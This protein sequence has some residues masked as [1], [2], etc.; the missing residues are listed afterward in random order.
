MTD[1]LLPPPALPPGLPGV[2]RRPAESAPVRYRDGTWAATF[3]RFRVANSRTGRFL[4]PPWSLALYGAA[5]FA[6]P[7]VVAGR[8]GW[9]FLE[10]RLRPPAGSPRPWIDPLARWARVLDERL[11]SLGIDLVLMPVPSK[12]W[13]HPEFVP[14]GWD[15]RQRLHGDLMAALREEGLRVLDLIDAW[16][17]TGDPAAG[18]CKTDSHWNWV[19]ARAAA[20]AIAGAAGVRVPDGERS[21]RLREVAVFPD[22][23]DLCRMFGVDLLL[24]RS[25]LLRRLLGLAAKPVGT[26]AAHTVVRADG[27]P[28]PG[29]PWSGHA[30][31]LVSG[32]S[33]SAWPEFDRYL[34]HASGGRIRLV[35]TRGGGISESLLAAVE[36]ALADPGSERPRTLVWEFPAVLLWIES[37][38]LLALGDVFGLLPAA[39][40]PLPGAA[41]RWQG[42]LAPG[43]FDAGPARSS[44]RLVSPRISTSDPGDLGVRL[45]GG[46]EGA[47]ALVAVRAGGETVFA[48]WRP[49]QRELVLPLPPAPGDAEIEVAVSAP[50]GA[51]RIR[52][53]SLELVTAPAI[54][55]P[56]REPEAPPPTGGP[57]LFRLPLPPGAEGARVGIRG[58]AAPG[59]SVTA[60]IEGRGES[61]PLG[62]PLTAPPGE[63]AA[64]W[65]LPPATPAG[66]VLVLSIEGPP[67]Q[68]ACQTWLAPVR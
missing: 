44:A 30:P 62:P 63:F 7:E 24:Q 54:P 27:A 40:S 65:R 53:D 52:L 2:H 42:P 32:T 33:F 9:L 15:A 48:R 21:T 68:A 57:S 8:E 35:A 11:A 20:E 43:A 41:A 13:R 29:T 1:I 23:G 3:E 10:S 12:A 47:P 5:S 67:A 18:F 19:G 4:I 26:Q 25:P 58:R 17:R 49:A 28:A 38:P 61:L 22:A 14:S 16:E 46:V 45:R 66:G 31:V 39:A 64:V 34:Q 50:L 59:A 55:L 51:A 6:G 36:A 60:A 37:A 56:L